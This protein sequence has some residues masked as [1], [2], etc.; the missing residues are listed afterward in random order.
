MRVLCRVWTPTGDVLLTDGA[1]ITLFDRVTGEVL[2]YVPGLVVDPRALEESMAWLSDSPVPRQLPITVLRAGLLDLEGR[3]EVSRLQSDD[4]DHA[5]REVVADGDL[6]S[7]VIESAWWSAVVVEDQQADR[8][9]LLDPMAVVGPSTWPRTTAERTADGWPAYTTGPQ[10]FDAR[11]EGAAYPIP[12][13]IPGI[14]GVVAAGTVL[15]DSAIS[16]PAM[17]VESAGLPP[18]DHALLVSVGRVQATHLRHISVSGSS[19]AYGERLAVQTGHDKRGRL[20][21]L[22]QPVAAVDLDAEHYV[23]FSEADGGGVANPYGSGL[24]R[25]FDHVIRWALDRSTLRVD[26]RE[27]PRLGSL[28]SL[29]VDTVVTAQARPFDWLRSELLSLLPVSVASGPGGLYVWPWI[30]ALA[31]PDVELELRVGVNCERPDP[32][33]SLDL[34]MTSRVTIAYGYDARGGNMVRRYTVCGERRPT[35]PPDEVGLDYWARRALESVGERE[36]EIEAPIVCDDT[37]A[38]LIAR[39]AVHVRCRPQHST[40]LEL[41]RDDRLRP[42]AIVRVVDSSPTVDTVAEVTD[43]RYTGGD[44]MAATVRTWAKQGREG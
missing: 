13:G 27:L 22:L 5:D 4:D 42:G 33:Q 19:A 2:R 11:I 32:W 30:P 9:L 35:D 14:Q 25:R 31:R 6:R 10:A 3:A 8:G 44:T 37:T 15:G 24:L 12:L 23:A 16:A 18:A 29:M 40:R 7:V 38:Q 43:V 36:I 1:A 39:M 20:V 34:D 28:A 26:R 17:M 41:A 21:S